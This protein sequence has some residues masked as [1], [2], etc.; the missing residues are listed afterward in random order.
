M[1]HFTHII[2]PL[3]FISQKRTVV[4]ADFVDATRPLV[5]ADTIASSPYLEM[6]DSGSGVLYFFN[7]IF[8]ITIVARRNFEF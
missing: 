2:Q 8:K 7:Q 4:N 6:C 1:A 3:D 5:I